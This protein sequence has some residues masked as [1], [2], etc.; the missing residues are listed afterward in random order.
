MQSKY[1]YI[2]SNSAGP[3]PTMIID[4]GRELAWNHKKQTDELLIC[5]HKVLQSG[6]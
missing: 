3:T 6:D 1:L 4:I 2:P 5:L